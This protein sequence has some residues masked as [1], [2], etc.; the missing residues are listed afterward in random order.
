MF[1]ICMTEIKVFRA[2]SFKIH[3]DIGDGL[4]LT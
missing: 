1:Q 2:D 4:N 3:K